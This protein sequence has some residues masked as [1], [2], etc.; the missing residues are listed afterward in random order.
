MSTQGVKRSANEFEF[1][2][3]LPFGP[4]L[5]VDSPL[6]R[7]DPRTRI[8]LVVL[9]MISLLAARQPLGL[10]LCL[11]V[12]L[13]GWWIAKVPFEPLWRGWLSAL[14]FLLFLVALQILFRVGT[15]PDVIFQIG[16]LVIS[17]ADLLAG[18]A[19]LLRFSGFM[20]VLGL[21]AASLSESEI[22]RGLEALLRPLSVLHIPTQDFVMA[23]QVTL[24]FFPLLAQTAERIAK[25]Q[26]SRGA[27]WRPAGWNLVQRVKQIAPV[28]VP[29]F[30]A[31]LRRAENM[32]LAMDARGYGS[33]PLR[34]SL[35]SLQYHWVDAVVLVVAGTFCL[36]VIIV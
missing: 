8:L 35:V 3:G 9:L 16:S 4:Y 1:M 7:L 19:V 14:P 32:A 25:A 10:V 11:A 2:R 5:P 36:V 13:I 31:S 27:D 23:V 24:R 22:T 6:H 34:T 15:D 21:A 12:I 20:A 33:L 18:L 17:S 29:L 28:I 26:A 30:V